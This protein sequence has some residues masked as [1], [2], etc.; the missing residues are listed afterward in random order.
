MKIFM[1]IFILLLGNTNLLANISGK[2]TDENNKPISGVNIYIKDT[3]EGTTTDNMG[4]FKIETELKGKHILIASFVG[5]L[6]IQKEIF[7][8]KHDIEFTIVLEH[9]LKYLYN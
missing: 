4:Y 6:T 7:I 9:F 5:C 2:V 3:Y 1:Q 8:E